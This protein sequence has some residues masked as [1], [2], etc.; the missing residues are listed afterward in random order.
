M[1]VYKVLQD[2]FC[3]HSK[4]SLYL[5]K[6]DILIME[7]CSV[8]S[9]KGYSYIELDLLTKLIR[10]DKTKTVNIVEPKLNIYGVRDL[11]HK[12]YDFEIAKLGIKERMSGTLNGYYEFKPI[13]DIT[14][15]YL[16]DIKLKELL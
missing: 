16:R 10:E 11:S 7:K 3:V 9:S 15:Q 5:K 6:D 12:S 13:E 4:E 8:L 14:V 2:Y 1:K